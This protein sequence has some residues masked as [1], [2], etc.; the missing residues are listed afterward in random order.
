MPS[1]GIGRSR[2][3]WPGAGY[4]R[5]LTALRCQPR[6]PH[7]RAAAHTRQVGVRSGRAS[8]CWRPCRHGGETSARHRACMSGRQA[9]RGRWVVSTLTACRSGCVSTRAGRAPH[10]GLHVLGLVA[11]GA[12][13]GGPVD[14]RAAAPDARRAP[15][16]LPRARAS[17]DTRTR[18]HHRRRRLDRAAL[19]ARRRLPG[20]RRLE[21]QG[22]G[23]AV[24]RVCAASSAAGADARRRDRRDARVGFSHRPAAGRARVGAGGSAV[25]GGV[26]ALARRSRIMPTSHASDPRAPSDCECDSA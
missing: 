16:H 17:P 24:W 4:A 13:R 18:G 25:E 19:P 23:R 7:R 21:G 3:P 2:R 15:A 22:R 5:P 14:A 8:A 12:A 11:H 6:P 1:N 20:L 10:G 9:R 26:S